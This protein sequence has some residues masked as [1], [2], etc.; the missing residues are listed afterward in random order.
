MLMHQEIDAIELLHAAWIDYE[1]GGD[2]SHLLALCAD[3]IEFWPPNAPPI[4]GREEVARYL[5]RTKTVIHDIKVSERRIRALL[6]TKSPINSSSTTPVGGHTRRP[7]HCAHISR[8]TALQPSRE[9][10]LLPK[11]F[12]TSSLLPRALRAAS[13]AFRL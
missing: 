8:I 10:F 2:L 12:E 1:R 11:D 6:I 7:R 5:S 4:I 3:D 13:G 9:Q